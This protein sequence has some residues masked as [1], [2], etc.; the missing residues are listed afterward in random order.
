[1][2]KHIVR[3]EDIQHKNM[4]ELDYKIQ[5]QRQKLIMIWLTNKQAEKEEKDLIEEQIPETSNAL[6]KIRKRKE[7]LN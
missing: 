2:M 7:H 3:I 1:M 5:I 6:V 4:F